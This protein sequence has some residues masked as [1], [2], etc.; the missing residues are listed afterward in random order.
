MNQSPN[1]NK[2]SR[3]YGIQKAKEFVIPKLSTPIT[4]D[5]YFKDFLTDV[6]AC[7]AY[8][9]RYSDQYPDI[10]KLTDVYNQ[11]D[12]FSPKFSLD[13]LAIKANVDI[14][15]FRR[16]IIS[17]IDY[18]CNDEAEMAVRLSKPELVRK[19]LQVAMDET[20]PDSYN[21]RA[22]WLE[23]LGFRKVNQNQRFININTG[24][25]TINANTQN[26][27]I[28]GLPSFAST[29]AE[30]EKVVNQTLKDAI[31]TKTKQLTT[32]EVIDITPEKE[33]ICQPQPE[34]N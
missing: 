5:D 15:T 19:S 27:V 9:E 28:N 34:Q 24:D 10:K 4:L 31:S 32:N 3:T 29:I 14:G 7:L 2:D 16:L 26:N 18:L 33:P 12:K 20:H 23:F 11:T 21:E 30:S 1:K 6:H 13:A 22:G 17:T 25:T 8:L